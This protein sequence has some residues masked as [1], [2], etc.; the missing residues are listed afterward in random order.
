MAISNKHRI[1]SLGSKEAFCS[2]SLNISNCRGKREF[3]KSQAHVDF[4]VSLRAGSHLRA[5]ARAAKSEFKS[6]AILQGVR[7]SEPALISVIF[8]LPPP[9]RRNEII[10]LNFAANI[11]FESKLDSSLTAQCPTSR[12]S[13]ILAS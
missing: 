4:I 1:F 11:K 12:E 6:E 10:Q 9:N 13:K 7:E 5:H 3:C 2:N 8:S